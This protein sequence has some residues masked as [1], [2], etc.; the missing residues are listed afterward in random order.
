M[1][2]PPANNPCWLRLAD[3]KVSGFETTHVALKFLLKRLQG[4]AVPA[5]TKARELHDFFTKYE[6]LLSKEIGSLNR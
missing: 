3:G 5:A 2:I 1:T 6:R 4:D